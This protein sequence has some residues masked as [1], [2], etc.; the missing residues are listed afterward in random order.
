M[1]LLITSL[2]ALLVTLPVSA[3]DNPSVGCVWN[4]QKGTCRVQLSSEIKQPVL[5]TLAAEAKL[6]NGRVIT[7]DKTGMLSASQSM[8]TAITATEANSIISMV[9][10]AGCR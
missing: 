1:K 2:T 5:C 3:T 10:A 6:E 8:S 9:A 4:A 7:L